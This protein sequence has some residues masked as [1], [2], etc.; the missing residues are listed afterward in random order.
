MTSSL[1]KDDLIATDPDIRTRLTNKYQLSSEAAEKI[2]EVMETTGMSF[3]E[4]AL[5][6][7]FIREQEV[8]ADV[9]QGDVL[10]GRTKLRHQ[11]GLI[12]TAL[13]RL[14]TKRDLVLR[15][16]SEVT[17]GPKLQASFDASNA[18]NEKMRALRT[19]L[20]LM[21]NASSGA[22]VFTVLSAEGGEGR[23]QLCAE[24]AISFSQ[25]G[26]RTLLVDADMRNPR[27]HELFGS[28]NEFGLSQAISQNTR[29][30]LHPVKGLVSMFLLTAGMIPANPLELLS[31]G[32][33]DK[34]L[35]DWRREYE[36]I[37]IDTPPVTRFADA[38]AIATMVGR[39]IIVSRAKVTSYKSTRDMMRR[40]ETTRAQVLGG[41]INHF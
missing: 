22:N 25:L 33:F 19:E 12:E 18:R 32:R 28:N 10:S 2:Y 39:A 1:P 34:L 38:V 37:L 21:S 13:N 20:L 6:L 27:Q 5:H 17:P 40:L 15:Q 29:P 9:L 41:V 4:A 23:S 8:A 3:P 14:S 16:G 7:G 31:D 24:L 35:N 26:R 30:Y 36:F 11:P